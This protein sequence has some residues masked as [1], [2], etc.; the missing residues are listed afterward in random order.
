[1]SGL[2]PLTIVSTVNNV[3]MTAS[4]W[5]ESALQYFVILCHSVNFGVDES[6]AEAACLRFA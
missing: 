2:G 3:Q 4:G 5:N 1:M 6:G